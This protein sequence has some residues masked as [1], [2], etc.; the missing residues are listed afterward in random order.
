MSQIWNLN[1][2]PYTHAQI[3]RLKEKGLNP[4]NEVEAPEAPVKEVK[5]PI[6]EK[7]EKSEIE[8]PSVK[9]VEKPLPKNFFELKKMAKA[10][11][12]EIEA[13]TKKSEIIKFLQSNK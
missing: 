9:E 11:G 5:K 8:V 13:K 12:M 10:K 6:A 7:V 1:G 2:R 4:V 3:M